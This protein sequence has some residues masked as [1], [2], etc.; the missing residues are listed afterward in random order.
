MV[1]VGDPDGAEISAT[2]RSRELLCIAPV[3]L[4]AVAWHLGHE[5]RCDDV[6]LHAEP[7]ELPVQH[8][9]RGPGFVADAKAAGVS[10][11]AEELAHGLGSVGDRPNRSDGASAF[12]YR[13]RDGF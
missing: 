9:S 12:R 13:D 1:R 2:I 6:A 11:L 10:Q 4:D 7:S 8:V 3:R 5:R